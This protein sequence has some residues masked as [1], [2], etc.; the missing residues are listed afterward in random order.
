MP[1]L[2]GATKFWK[3]Q[4]VLTSPASKVSLRI[5]SKGSLPSDLPLWD[6]SLE[7]RIQSQ[8][9]TWVQ[10]AAKKIEINN[11]GSAWAEEGLFQRGRA[12]RKHE[13]PRSAQE[14][15]SSSSSSD[16]PTYEVDSILGCAVYSAGDVFYL[17]HW[18]GYGHDVD[19]WEPKR[20]VRHLT[21]F[22]IFANRSHDLL[23]PRAPRSRWRCRGWDIVIDP[24]NFRDARLP[25]IS[26][27]GAEVEDSDASFQSSDDDDDH[28]HDEQDELLLDA[29]FDV[30]D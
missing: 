23:I 11:Y 17:V 16:G 19:T 8:I 6:T 9:A 7:G 12:W 26:L 24:D 10:K 4:A 28:P 3:P 27:D 20:R 15:E 18:K 30:D 14:E 1:P 25:I 5:L 22:G 2:S 13:V 21:A 29:A